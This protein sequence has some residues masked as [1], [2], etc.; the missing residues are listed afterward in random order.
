MRT[1]NKHIRMIS[2][3]LCNTED[4]GNDAANL[5]LITRIN[6]L[7]QYIQIESSYFK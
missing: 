7:L 5:A 3:G 1:A 6:D 4:W 2:E